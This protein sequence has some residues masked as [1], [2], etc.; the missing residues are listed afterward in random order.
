MIGT[1]SLRSHQLNGAAGLLPT[2]AGSPSLQPWRPAMS[3]RQVG[4]GAARAL[5]ASSWG[6]QRSGRRGAP[7]RL[8][9]HAGGRPFADFLQ[10]EEVRGCCR[11]P[12]PP[13]SRVAGCR[14]RAH[15]TL[16]F[17][18][19][20]VQRGSDAP[21]PQAPPGQLGGG[22]AEELVDRAV[23]GGSMPGAL[24]VAEQR[25]SWRAPKRTSL[26]AS[27]G[28]PL[29]QTTLFFAPPSSHARDLCWR[30]PERRCRRC[31]IASPLT[32]GTA[33]RVARCRCAAGSCAQPCSL[34][35]V[36]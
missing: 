32:R 27:Q 14:R 31:E 1:L 18:D 30:R 33:S 21:P 26:Q 22:K 17:P 20:P 7:F 11:H 6:R 25:G 19:S 13:G 9:P 35:K 15:L 10:F 2:Q 34:R 28:Q 4:L 24:T 5:P 36:R 8:A 16:C 23:R 3:L 29:V 12:R